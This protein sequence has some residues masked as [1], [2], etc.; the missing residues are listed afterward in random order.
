MHSHFLN[1]NFFNGFI[2]PFSYNG[3]FRRLQMTWRR[4]NVGSFI[5]PGNFYNYID[6]S[7]TDTTQWKIRK[8]P[9]PRPVHIIYISSLH[10]A[11]VLSSTTPSRSIPMLIIPGLKG[12]VNYMILTLTIFLDLDL[13]HSPNYD[14]ELIERDNDIQ[15]GWVVSWLQP[16]Y[17]IEF[18]GYQVSW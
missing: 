15:A 1:R 2:G 7:G 9:F 17:G 16:R 10:L 4:N 13:L 3:S 14:T 8:I 11:M 18:M 12:D 6:V 5:L